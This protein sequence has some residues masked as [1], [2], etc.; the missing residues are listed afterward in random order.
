M[1]RLNGWMWLGLAL[2]LCVS[3]S[4]TFAQRQTSVQVV[5]QIGPAH[6]EGVFVLDQATMEAHAT[7]YVAEDTNFPDD[8]R[9]EFRG[10]TVE[11]MLELTQAEDIAGVTFIASNVYVTYEPL[12]QIL[13]D[14]VMLAFASNG[15]RIK[16]NRGGPYM[17]MREQPGNPGL[18]NW[19][20]DTIILGT[21][22]QPE[23][24]VTQGGQ[25]AP[26]TYEQIAGLPRVGFEG[27]LPLPRGFRE[28]LPAPTRENK[29]EA[30]RL[31]ELLKGYSG[32]SQA[33]LVP[34]VGKPVTL[35]AADLDLPVQVLHSFDGKRILSAYGGPF[36]AVFPI[37]DQPE[38][39]QRM[40]QVLFFLRRIELF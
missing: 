32:Y 24:L 14:K 12:E 40:P 31:S 27:V 34:H 30:V 35:Q 8:G 29:V 36:S 38:L 33:R 3:A 6:R 37:D 22:Q 20:V 18:Y 13:R 9:N 2:A 23:I 10:I 1:Q 17:I 7:T 15:K 21:S 16:K 5:G 28:S 19:Y 11:T 39:R 26:L 25:T 4:V